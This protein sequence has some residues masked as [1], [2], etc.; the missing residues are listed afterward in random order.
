MVFHSPFWQGHASALP[1]PLQVIQ[2][3]TIWVTHSII[4]ELQTQSFCLTPLHFIL[5]PS[6]SCYSSSL[7]PVFFIL[8]FS[9][10]SPYSSFDSVVFAAVVKWPF[11]GHW[12]L[13]WPIAYCHMILVAID[14]VWISNQI[15][16][17][18]HKS[19]GHT[20]SFQSVT[21]F[22]N[23]CLVVASNGRRSPSSGFPNCPWPQRP[24]SHSNSSYWLN[25][26]SS[27]TNC[28]SWLVLLIT[29]RHGP[30]RKHCSSVAV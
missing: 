21:A 25:C 30:H 24:A 6:S 11:L 2:H 13:F 17:T 14:K 22:T 26:S 16:C 15:Y 9:F 10:T 20:R 7:F 5:L 1:Y 18:L 8:F 19:L 27:V 4:K 3:Y 29:S 12:A 28:N 23:R